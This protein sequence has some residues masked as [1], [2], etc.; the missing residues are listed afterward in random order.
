MPGVHDPCGSGEMI[1]PHDL[2]GHEVAIIRESAECRVGQVGLF[3]EID[4][5]A[6]S[7]P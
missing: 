1:D 7:V 6:A 4:A 3:R 2:S 5:T